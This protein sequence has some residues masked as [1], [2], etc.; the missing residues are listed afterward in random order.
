MLSLLTV[1]VS[2]QDKKADRKKKAKAKMERMESRSPEQMA[3]LQT[4]QMAIDLDLT[5]AQQKEIYA[6]H[7]EQAV[8][9]KAQMA[10]WREMRNNDEMP[11]ESDRMKM[12]SA[13]L[14]DEKAL[15]DKMKKVLNDEQYAKWKSD[16]EEKRKNMTHRRGG[17]RG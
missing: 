2:A 6:I 15:Q 14:D 4:K 3:E 16:R 17:R 12:R 8:K 10:K 11:S 1:A 9:R 13:R 5:D 7:K